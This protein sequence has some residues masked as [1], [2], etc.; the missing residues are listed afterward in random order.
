MDDGVVTFKDY[1]RIQENLIPNLN[2][3]LSQIEKSDTASVEF[4]KNDKEC[5]FY[6]GMLFANGIKIKLSN[7]EVLEGEFENEDYKEKGKS[8]PIMVYVWSKLFDPEWPKDEPINDMAVLLANVKRLGLDLKLTRV[9]NRAQKNKLFLICPV[10]GSSE[11]T[12]TWIENY[13]TVM[14]H[15]G[16]NVHAPHLDTNQVDK[17]AGYAICRQNAE[18]IGKSQ[19]VELL[20]NPSSNGSAFDLGVAY[21]LRKPIR[22]LNDDSFV[23][24]DDNVIDQIILRWPYNENKRANSVKDTYAKVRARVNQAIRRMY[25]KV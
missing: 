21:A 8:F 9:P 12:K 17:F 24:N 19:E 4:N 25:Q 7:E 10:R 5:L 2:E 14:S 16:F 13:K 15:Y 11:E 23:F 3:L 22:L 6:L 18:A 1:F 20:Y